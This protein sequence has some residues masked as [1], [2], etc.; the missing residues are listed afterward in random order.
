MKRRMLGEDEVPASNLKPVAF[1]RGYARRRDGTGPRA[2]TSACPR[3]PR[4]IPDAPS[5][6]P[7]LEGW[8]NERPQIYGDDEDVLRDL[9]P[10][11]EMRSARKMAVARRSR[12]RTPKLVPVQGDYTPSVFVG[13]GEMDGLITST[14]NTLKSRIQKTAEQTGQKIESDIKKV[15]ASTKAGVETAKAM[16]SS[17]AKDLKQMKPAGG[18]VPM[19]E[20]K[21]VSVAPTVPT[22]PKR[23]PLLGS[24]YQT[25][26]PDEAVREMKRELDEK[27]V[28]SEKRQALWVVTKEEVMPLATTEE[29]YIFQ[30]TFTGGAVD[31]AKKNKWLLIGG[32]IGLL[33]VAGVGGYLLLRKKQPQIVQMV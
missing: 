10:Q 33:V 23:Y 19:P 3:T 25:L 8:L 1:T 22:A 18:I 14:A 26:S 6:T 13:I 28:T 27:K 29:Q 12:N 30:Q 32:G 9:T 15:K 11:V 31:W 21:E 20:K 16:G 24:K 17:V 2:G 7:T 4:P 5:I